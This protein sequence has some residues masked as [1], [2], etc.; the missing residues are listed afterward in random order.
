MTALPTVTLPAVRCRNTVSCP[1]TPYC[2][3]K[4][5]NTYYRVYSA[6]ASVTLQVALPVTCSTGPC[7]PVAL[8]ADGCSASYADLPPVLISRSDWLADGDSC[9]LL[10]SGMGLITQPV[11]PVL[12]VRSTADP[13]VTAAQLTQCSLQ[14]PRAAKSRKLAVGLTA[15]GSAL[16]GCGLFALCFFAKKCTCTVNGEVVY[17]T[18]RDAA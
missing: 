5:L 12:T 9:K 10:I 13:R 14:F 6:L 7:A 18:D 17:D 15:A 1:T 16:L 8:V 3:G 11:Q 2:G 4:S